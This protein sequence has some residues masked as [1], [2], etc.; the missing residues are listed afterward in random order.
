MII[1]SV[2]TS[3]ASSRIDLGALCAHVTA[4]IAGGCVMSSLSLSVLHGT[5]DAMI[6]FRII[7]RPS[8]PPSI[9]ASR[10]R[11][12][13]RTG[14]HTEKDFLYSLW[15]CSSGFW[16]SA[17]PFSPPSYISFLLSFLEKSSCRQGAYETIP[18]RPVAHYSLASLEV[19][20]NKSHGPGTHHAP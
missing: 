4:R 6:P 1:N 9:T 14:G 17:N 13:R 8:L 2:M 15:S 20:P 7:A 5:I 19:L 12:I 3:L 18:K 11:T 16:A 10:K